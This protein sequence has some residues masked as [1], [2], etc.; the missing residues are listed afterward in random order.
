VG[1]AV[2]KVFGLQVGRTGLT[3]REALTKG[4]AVSVAVVK[5]SD[6]ARY[7]PDN[8]RLDVKLIMERDGR[9]LL[10]A[11]MIGAQGAAKRIDVLAAALYAKMTVDDLTRIDYAYAPPYAGVWDATLVAAN[12]AGK[13]R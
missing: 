12:V 3:E 13:C 4:L 5:A 2:A 8:T 11:Q 10:G 6:H 9:R 7:Y 1:T